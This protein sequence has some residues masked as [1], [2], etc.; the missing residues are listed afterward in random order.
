M[1]EMSLYRILRAHARVAITFRASLVAFMS[2]NCHMED[3]IWERA[4]RDCRSNDLKRLRHI[5]DPWLEIE[6]Q[7]YSF[8]SFCSLMHFVWLWRSKKT[9]IIN[10]FWGIWGFDWTLEPY[11]LI[12]YL[13][14]IQN[15]PCHITSSPHL[16]VFF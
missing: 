1:S 7:S 5:D 9:I 6:C 8:L 2:L 14:V 3:I 15:A 4:R 12:P 10:A 13:W 11:Q 16:M